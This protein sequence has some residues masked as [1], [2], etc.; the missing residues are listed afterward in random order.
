MLFGF[1]LFFT[2]D[3][4]VLSQLQPFAIT[5]TTERSYYWIQLFFL[6]CNVNVDSQQRESIV[7]KN[8]KGATNSPAESS[9]WGTQWLL[10]SCSLCHHSQK[11]SQGLSMWCCSKFW[12]AFWLTTVRCKVPLQG[13]H[14]DLGCISVKLV[15]KL[16]PSAA[17]HSKV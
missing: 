16:A 13:F 17:A 5:S 14:T 3:K 1:K 8:F 6:E 2:I 9:L 10:M 11:T 12:V 15:S 7:C 4:K